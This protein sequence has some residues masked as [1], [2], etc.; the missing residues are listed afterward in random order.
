MGKGIVVGEGGSEVLA[1][2][3]NDLIEGPDPL[4]SSHIREGIVI[5][6]ESSDGVRWAKH[7]S[8]SFKCLDQSLRD[9]DKFTDPEE[10]A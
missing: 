7:K 6:V 10:V 1:E 8:F 3:L 9:N 2:G 4:D 5:R